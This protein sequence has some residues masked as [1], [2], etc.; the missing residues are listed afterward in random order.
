MADGVIDLATIPFARSLVTDWSTVG[1]AGIRISQRD[2]KGAALL[3]LGRKVDIPSAGPMTLPAPNTWA[4][5]G[6]TR[7]L[8]QG[9]KEFLLID[10]SIGG[11]E[12]AERATHMTGGGTTA[13]SLDVTDRVLLLDVAGSAAGQLF[14]K[15]TSLKAALLPSGACCRTRFA[16]LQATVLRDQAPGDFSLIT[17][18]ST[19]VYL[20]CW[21]ARAAQ[22]LA[23]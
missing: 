9:P 5:N 19:A 15:G 8:W 16:N 14:S 23:L 2:V 22:D 21:L 12:L 6:T 3:K 7:W 17:E 1:H 4:L 11:A 20:H 18:R 13:L 10:T